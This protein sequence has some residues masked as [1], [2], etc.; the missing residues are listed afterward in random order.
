MHA[1]RWLLVLVTAAAIATAGCRLFKR[2]LP[3]D[4]RRGGL[5]LVYAVDSTPETGG[6]EPALAAQA[7]ATITQRIV[8]LGLCQPDVK[9]A[10]REITVRLPA[11]CGPEIDRIKRLLRVGGR[12]E[13]REID[14]GTALAALAERVA[15]AGLTLGT[16]T[17]SDHGTGQA[18]QAHM[19]EGPLEGIE[20]FRGGL[21]PDA[22]PASV[23][24][25]VEPPAAER[26]RARLYLVKREAQVTG[27]YLRDARVGADPMTASPN[28][29]LEFDAAGAER[30]R[31][32]TERIKGRKLAIVLD[33]RIM[34]APVVMEAI[35]GGRAMITMGRAE[36]GEAQFAEARDLTLALRSG[37][38]P[39]PLVLVRENII[40]QSR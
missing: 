39:A 36:S 2:G 30:F 24:A 33:R 40:A 28:V 5:E 9:A 19:V 32:L 37:A 38:L 13:F 14:D 15:V 7:V 21:A 35:G 3:A 22:L 26:D 27:A 29:S 17:W 6:R 8:A 25:L 4:F 10:G 11:A 31:A 16:D 20:R 18:R 12:L 1:P 23:E 34:S